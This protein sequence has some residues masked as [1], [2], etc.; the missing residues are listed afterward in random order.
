MGF[1]I[2]AF[3]GI[4]IAI[5]C[6]VEATKKSV[7]YDENPDWT[8]YALAGL[9]Q[10]TFVAAVYAIEMYLFVKLAENSEDIPSISNFGEFMKSAITAF[11]YM[12]AMYAVGTGY[13][14]G[15]KLKAEN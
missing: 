11:L 10:F 7:S 13:A 12:G 1:L 15:A 2:T 5:W 9:W 8:N 4:I 14:I 3:F 6:A